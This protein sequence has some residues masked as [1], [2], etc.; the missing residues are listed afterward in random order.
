M[1]RSKNCDPLKEINSSDQSTSRY[2]DKQATLKNL[3]K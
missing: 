3:E 2:L 1:I